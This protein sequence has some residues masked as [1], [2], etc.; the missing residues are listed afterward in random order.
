[1][2]ECHPFV[3]GFKV[4]SNVGVRLCRLREYLAD[5]SHVERVLLNDMAYPLEDFVSFFPT[6]SRSSSHVDEYAGGYCDA[7]GL[8]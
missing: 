8:F 1:M 5:V 4:L 6:T 7:T 2:N 3:A